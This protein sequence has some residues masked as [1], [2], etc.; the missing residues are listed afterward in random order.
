MVINKILSLLISCLLIGSFI[1][2][3]FGIEG[4][5]AYPILTTTSFIIIIASCFIFKILPQKYFNPFKLLAYLFWL[6][7]EIITSSWQVTKIIWTRNLSINPRIIEI[8]T[9]LEE[10]SPAVVVLANSITLT[11]GTYTLDILENNKLKVHALTTSNIRD[12]VAHKT[13]QK[14]VK[15]SF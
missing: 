14:K 5:R 13:M 15:E 1:F 6:I 2:I 3:I 7:K 12:L 9:G 10:L 8:E 4:A 11:P